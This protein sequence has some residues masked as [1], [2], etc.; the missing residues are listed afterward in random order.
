MRL[1]IEMVGLVAGISTQE[2]ICRDVHIEVGRHICQRRIAQFQIELRADRVV[3]IVRLSRE[4]RDRRRQERVGRQ[5]QDFRPPSIVPG[6]VMKELV[7]RQPAGFTI[8]ALRQQVGRVPFLLDIIAPEVGG[9]RRRR[10]VKCGQPEPEIVL[11][12][13]ARCLIAVGIGVIDPGAQRQFIADRH[14]LHRGP[15]GEA[16]IA[17]LD[18][19]IG[20]IVARWSSEGDV[21][22]PA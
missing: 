21:D 1:L 19:K 10:L 15:V 3:F 8:D 11:R 5:G 9:E 13:G 16:E 7:G 18:K 12:V 22:R 6:I 17:D 14:I 20:F 4:R 2:I